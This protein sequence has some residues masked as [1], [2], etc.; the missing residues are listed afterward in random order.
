MKFFESSLI[1]GLWLA[2]IAAF[3][4]LIHFFFSLPMRRMERARL[5]LD[6]V[7]S[8][9][10]RGQAVEEMILSLASS[11]DRTIGM[12]FHLLA[13]YVEG[14]SRFGDAL[15]KVPRF[16]PPQIS[17]ILRAGEKLGD[18][19][20]VLPACRELLLDRPAAV[21]SAMHY[22]I[23]VVLLFSPVFIFVVTMTMVFVI[24]KFKE[25]AAG[26]GIHLPLMAQFV[27]THTSWLIASE[28][29]ITIMMLLATLLYIGGPGF[30]RWFQFRGL[31][32]VDWIAWHVP[33]K[34]KRLQR[35]IFRHARRF[36]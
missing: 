6:L 26:M 13:A 22:L 29:I 27:F 35:T 16:L 7:V 20:K 14:G 4:F 3:V 1:F 30:V 24:P 8:A 21:R 11:R 19:K 2:A 5:F 18:P 36:A 34:Q 9:L 23:F 28:L 10:N 25:V 33:W 12:R 17:A 32:V 15:E 31:P